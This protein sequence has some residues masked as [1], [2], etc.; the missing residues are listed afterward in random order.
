MQ[1][2][3]ANL[4]FIIALIVSVG[5]TSLGCQQGVRKEESASVYNSGLDKCK[6]ISDELKTLGIMTEGPSPSKEN[7]AEA[8]LPEKMKSEDLGKAQDLLQDYITTA[9]QLLRLGDTDVVIFPERS[10]IQTGVARASRYLGQIYA[11]RATV[12]YENVVLSSEIDFAEFEARLAQTS[13][14]MKAL[15]AVGIDVTKDDAAKKLANDVKQIGLSNLKEYYARCQQLM[16]DGLRMKVLSSRNKAWNMEGLERGADSLEQ[17][18]HYYWRLGEII[19]GEID[20]RE[21]S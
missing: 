15:Q 14:N 21:Q 3:Q 6:K 16:N 18:G 13:A 8:L 17:I 20:S 10:Q 19:K 7:S 2:R 5:A 4:I 12:E 1:T 11:K 9:Q